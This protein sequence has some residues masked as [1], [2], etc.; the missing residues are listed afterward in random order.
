MEGRPG[1][2]IARAVVA[3]VA[4]IGAL[5]A[6]APASADDPGRWTVVDRASIPL[7][8][9]QGMT[10]APNGDL[11]FDGINVGLYRTDSQLFEERA[12]PNAIPPAV[13]AA[14]GFN[15]IGDLTYDT[16]EGGRV[17]LPL[18]CYYPGT[19][20]GANTCGNGAIGVA[21]P[22]TLAW[23]YYV[24]LDPTEISKAMWTE[25]SPDGR[26]VWTSSGTDLL[27]YSADQVSA[28]NAGPG[29][30]PLKARKRVAGVLRAS[31][32]SGGAFWGGRLYLAYDRGSYIQVLSYPVDPVTG[33]VG[34]AW[35]LEIQRTKSSSLYETE[36]LAVANA[37]GGVLHWQVQPQSPFYSRIIHFVPAG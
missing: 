29:G 21:D 36:G 20:G 18:E 26:W 24:K 19:P 12:T 16:G 28:V 2:G 11:F 27:A 4:S 25:V 9:F 7:V 17:L 31:S 6:A 33:D 14:E 22:D 5:V 35:R 3:A 1:R 37:L 32:V 30:A 23:R 8:Y 13:G 10:S 34:T 15:H